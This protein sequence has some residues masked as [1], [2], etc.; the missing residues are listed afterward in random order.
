MSSARHLRLLVTTW[1]VVSATLGAV[2]VDGSLP[3]ATAGDR[4]T[5]ADASPAMPSGDD[6]TETATPSATS[7]SHP[8]STATGTADGTKGDETEGDG[9]EESGTEGTTTGEAGTPGAGT[10]GSGAD[11]TGTPATGTTATTATGPES[12]AAPEDGAVE[13]EPD[14]GAFAPNN[15]V[16]PGQRTRLV[17]QV[18]N[19]G[20]VDDGGLDTPPEAERQVTTARDVSVTLE[21][22]DAPADVRTG[23]TALG[24]L[25]SGSIAQ[26][27]FDVVV[28]EDAE[29]GVYELDVVVEYDYTESVSGDERDDESETETLTVAI[30]VTENARFEVVD[31][32][33]DLQVGERG[34]VEVTFENVGEETVR[35][36]AV[37]FR[38]RNA[39]LRVDTGSETARFAGEWEPGEE[40]TVEFQATAANTSAPQRYAL[41]ATVAYT[42]GD[43]VRRNSTPLVF[44]VRPD[45]EQTFS[46]D[47]VEGD[48]RVGEDGTVTGTVTNEGPGPVADAV[49]RLVDEDGD[50]V[51]RRSTAVLGD[52]D[53]GEDADFSIPVRVPDDAEPGQ[54]QLSFVV[55]YLNRDGDPRTSNQLR[56]TV[57]VDEERDRFEVIDS[58]ADVQAGESGT[59]SLEIEN[60]GDEDI[61]DAT[62]VLSSPD[63]D[64]V[65]DS[66]GNASRFVGAWDEGDEETVAV[67]ATAA[68]G[69]GGQRFPI[70]VTVRYTDADG[71]RRRSDALVV[72]VTPE[73]EQR[74]A[75]GDVTST[76][77]VGE[78]GR[79]NGTVTNTGP[80][81]VSNAVLRLTST[82]ENLDPR[83]TE[84]VLGD[85]EEDGDVGFSLPISVP[86]TAQPG[87]RRLTFVV[88]YVTAGG[89]RRTSDPISVVANVTSGTDRLVIESVSS[90][91]QADDTGSVVLEV[92]NRGNE[93]LSDATVS[94]ATESRQ[95]QVGDGVN[96]TRFVGDWPS[97][98]TRTVRY[99]VR[100]S[101]GTGNQTFPF[102]ASVD[103]E[104]EEG[105]SRRSDALPFGATPA[106]EQSFATRAVESTLRV[107]EEGRATVRLTNRGPGTVSAVALELVTDAPNVNPVETEV[108]V[109]DLAPGESTTLAFPVEI[110]ESADAETRQLTYRVRYA[111]DDG[112]RRTSDVLTTDVRV[113]P[114][115]DP[116]VVDTAEATVTV[117]GDGT[118]ALV[119]T[120]N[121]GEPLRDIQA[122]AFADAPLSVDDD[123]AF[124]ASL[125]PNE[126][127]TIRFDVSAGGEAGTKTYPLSV[128]FLYTTPDGDQRLSDPVD[129]GVTVVEPPDDDVLELVLLF[130]GVVALLLIALW[131][132]RRRRR[133]RGDEAEDASADGG[134][135]DASADGDGA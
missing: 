36:A 58:N 110:S 67:E 61:T 35:D 107:G 51:A 133:G 39:D 56:G 66:G 90:E 27:G 98:E 125:D 78:E 123:Q 45:E 74:F 33:S 84:A 121:R 96:D 21:A 126:S 95:L 6:E 31:V 48:L 24:D 16:A 77:R 25:P 83:E 57:D 102:R 115:R 11:G 68:N 79:V 92:T 82:D 47:D 80:R 9:A 5:P 19:G 94:L 63:D 20:T 62:V 29:P 18:T 81:G 91:L 113:A 10:R 42:D 14:L 116:F 122:K 32:D 3:S 12:T 50:V 73:A 127:A 105:Q 99:R 104:D 130:L 13:G 132:L 17:V 28:D 37:T 60:V 129:V 112:D 65:L 108:A 41:E 15:T 53:D 120:N 34:T 64:L 4:S 119:V 131:L 7:T 117:G 70:E 23:T 97:G 44:G 46:V 8:P 1:V 43:G 40:K 49:V 128:D 111:D 69:T 72:G 124:V 30:V 93:T 75:V 134:A 135:D 88:E 52:L 55:E 106:A 114:E 101:N 87:E 54:R 38:S 59:L 109:G 118:L 76:L 89:D 26:S 100:A 85:I 71:D 22:D 103:Y 2:V 86:D